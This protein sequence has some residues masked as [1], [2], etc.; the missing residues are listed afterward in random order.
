MRPYERRAEDK[1]PLRK[2]DIAQSR[3]VHYLLVHAAPT[4]LLPWDEA[5]QEKGQG[6]GARR[7]RKKTP[8]EPSTAAE[9]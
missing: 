8:G 2:L 1:D 3:R 9:R 4:R 5:L 7:R 6:D